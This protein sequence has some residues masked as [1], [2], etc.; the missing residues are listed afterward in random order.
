MKYYQLR[1]EE[2]G[3][4]SDCPTFESMAEARSAAVS[5]CRYHSVIE[6]DESEVRP[7]KPINLHSTCLKCARCAAPMAAREE[8]KRQLGEK[9]NWE[10]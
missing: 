3:Y 5:K 10:R 1:N 6:V 2:L 4:V 8:L 9:Y 7:C